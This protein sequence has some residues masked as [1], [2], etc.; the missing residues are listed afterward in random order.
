MKII[1][2]GRIPEEIE[3]VKKCHN[4]GT[5]FSFKLREA[6]LDFDQRDGDYYSI[7]CPLCSKSVTFTKGTTI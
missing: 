2:T 7:E 5:E 6:K 3:Y 1:K 4:C